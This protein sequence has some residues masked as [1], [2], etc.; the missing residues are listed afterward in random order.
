MNSWFDGV[1][2]F[3]HRR[4]SLSAVLLVVGMTAVFLLFREYLDSR[5]WGW[6]YL[7]IVGAVAGTAGMKPALLAS[8]LS[9][10]SWN[11]F[12]I[13]PYHTLIVADPQD[14]IQLLVYLA[15]AT[16]VGLQ[17]GRLRE[18]EAEARREERFAGALSRLSAGLVSSGSLGDIASLAVAEVRS[19]MPGSRL[20][21]WVPGTPT[22]S[23][24][25][26]AHDAGDGPASRVRASFER[27]VAYGLPSRPPSES[28]GMWPVVAVETGQGDVAIPLRSSGT[29]EGVLQVELAELRGPDHE[30]ALFLVST[31]NL[32]AAFLEARR[33]ARVAN[34]AIAEREAERLRAA[35]VSSVSHEL[36]TPLAGVTAA[37]TDLLEPDVSLDEEAVRARL[38][39]ATRDLKRLDAAIADLLDAS[40]LEARAWAPRCDVYEVGE[41]LGDVLVRLADGPRSRVD[42]A[43]PTG[44][45]SVFVDFV[46]VSKALGHV[47]DNALKY[48]RGSVRIAA[49]VGGDGMLE[50]RVSDEGPGMAVN[51]REHVFEKFYRGEAGRSSASSTGLGLAITRDLLEANGGSI[52]IESTGPAGTSMLITLPTEGAKEDE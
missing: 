23:L 5:H 1:R 47:V 50:C 2:D 41:I 10:L 6:P 25:S 13:P 22:G 38:A 42:L 37:V 4:G 39:V 46:Q 24:R 16:A 29:I 3:M 8:A 48:S 12:F 52:V 36:K 33:L 31:A 35:L 15:V 17:T 20:N 11:F 51:E 26:V 21:V 34:A 19:V 32:I 49:R 7:L 28:H 44:L 30:E 40:R 9:F 18:R 45:P 43:I 14:L 27:D